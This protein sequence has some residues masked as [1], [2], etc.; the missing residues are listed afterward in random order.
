MSD[1]WVVVYERVVANLGFVKRWTVNCGLVGVYENGTIQL[2][3]KG[4]G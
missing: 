3:D 1:G 2:F 4:V